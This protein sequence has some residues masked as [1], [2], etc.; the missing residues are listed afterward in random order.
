MRTQSKNVYLHAPLYRMVKLA[1]P[2]PKVERKEKK[3][4]GGYYNVKV[5]DEDLTTL[6]VRYLNGE[7]MVDLCAE[8]GYDVKTAYKWSSGMSRGHCLLQA[9]KIAGKASK[10]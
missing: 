10:P 1:P 6:L 8:H 4:T 2:T 9:E 7:R 5:S 3:K